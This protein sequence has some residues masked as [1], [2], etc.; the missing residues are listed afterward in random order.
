MVRRT[1]HDNTQNIQSAK[2]SVGK[3]DPGFILSIRFVR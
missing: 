3:E 2:M 1:Q